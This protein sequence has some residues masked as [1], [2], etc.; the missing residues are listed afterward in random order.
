M[1]YYSDFTIKV[2]CKDQEQKKKILYSM[3][4]VSGYS[5]HKVAGTDYDFLI[6]EA[7]WYSCPTDMKDVSNEFKDVLFTIHGH[8]EDGLRWVHYFKGGKASEM[9]E[10]EIIF[11]QFEESLLK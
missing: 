10:P 2:D 7:K 5:F 1:G 11:P 3:Q 6:N 8:G 4:L 9:L